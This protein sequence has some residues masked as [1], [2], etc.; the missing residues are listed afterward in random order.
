MILLSFFFQALLEIFKLGF[1][2]DQFMVKNSLRIFVFLYF[3]PWWLWK[4]GILLIQVLDLLL[5]QRLGGLGLFGFENQLLYV[6]FWGHKLL[7][8][9]SGQ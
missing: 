7:L 1:I 2:L 5:E 8:K 3:Q 6:G 4:L 9:W